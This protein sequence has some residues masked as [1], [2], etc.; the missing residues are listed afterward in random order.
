MTT[1]KFP[2]ALEFSGDLA[3][4]YQLAEFGK[5]VDQIDR[6]TSSHRLQRTALD[7]AIRSA[8]LLGSIPPSPRRYQAGSIALVNRRTGA[9]RL[10]R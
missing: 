7:W 8:E 2:W 1:A 9:R 5:I 4:R 6:Y 3:R 10:I